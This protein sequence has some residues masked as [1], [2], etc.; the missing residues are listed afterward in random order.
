[1]PRSK[2]ILQPNEKRCWY[3]GSHYWLQVH[4]C[5]YGPKNRT[6]SDK[7]G[8]WVWLCEAHHTGPC[9]VH[10]K[11]GDFLDKRLKI[12]C[13]KKFEETHSRKEFMKIIGRNYLE[14]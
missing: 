12:E 6:N 4:H 14:D 10:N 7:N 11:G 8:F 5:Y 13:Q 2:S 1:M 9:G 3:C